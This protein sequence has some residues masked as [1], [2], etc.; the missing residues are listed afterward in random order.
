VTVVVNSI[1]SNTNFGFTFYNPVITSLSPPAGQVGATVTVAGTGFGIDQGDQVLFNGLAGQVLSWSD[2]S[3]TVGVPFPATSGPVKVVKGGVS[4]NSISFS[5][6]TLGVTSISPTSGP[7]GS[8]VTISGTGFG[9]NRTNSGVDF[10]GTPA[11]IQ[12]WVIR[13]SLRSCREEPPVGL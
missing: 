6:E 13:R 5:V 3:I 12:S 9:A 8:L 2:T 4:S 7:A 11:N 1:Q 10:Y